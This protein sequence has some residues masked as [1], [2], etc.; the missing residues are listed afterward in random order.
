[1]FSVLG[2]RIVFSIVAILGFCWLLLMIWLTSEQKKF[3][4]DQLRSQ[5]EGVYHYIVLSRH[6]IASKGGIYVKEGDKYK[7]VTPSHFTKD[8]A[9]YA[10]DRLPYRVKVAVLHTKNPFHVPDGFEKE[11]ILELQKGGEERYGG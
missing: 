2:K 10:Q 5:A 3:L 1:M 11:A 6:W 7:L 9:N 8:V 4:L